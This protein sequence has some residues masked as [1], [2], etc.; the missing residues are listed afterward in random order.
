HVILESLEGRQ[1]AGINNHS[2]PDHADIVVT[3][4]LTIQYHTSG[5]SANFADLKG[6]TDLH[7]RHDLLFIFRR[8]HAFHRRFK[9]V[10]GVVYNGV[11][12]DV[13]LLLFSQISCADGRTYLETDNNSV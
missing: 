13:D 4:D 7:V 11:Q 3:I 10:N 5:N 12:P 6:F 8:E 9:L 2:F 1:P